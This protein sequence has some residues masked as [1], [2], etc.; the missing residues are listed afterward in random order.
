MG[1]GLA[2]W[3]VALQRLKDPFKVETAH[4]LKAS[5]KLQGREPLLL[6]VFFLYGEVDKVR[7]SQSGEAR[8]ACCTVS[9]CMIHYAVRL[10]QPTTTEEHR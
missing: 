9:Y 5:F 8:D 2:A 4:R 7:A 1:A 3:T 10:L 6:R